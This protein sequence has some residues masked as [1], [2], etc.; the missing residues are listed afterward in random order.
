MPAVFLLIRSALLRILGSRL[1]RTAARFLSRSVSTAAVH[2]SAALRLVWERISSQ[3]SKEA[4]LGCVLCILN[5]HKK[6]DN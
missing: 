6:V 3:E 2:L 5:M 1:A 4:I